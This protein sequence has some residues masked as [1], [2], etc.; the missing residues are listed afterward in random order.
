M[1]PAGPCCLSTPT[2][3]SHSS[4]P[5]WAKVGQ[6]NEVKASS[7]RGF[8]GKE[9]K[10]PYNH[11]PDISIFRASEQVREFVSYGESRVITKN[12]NSYS[13]HKFYHLSLWSFLPLGKK[14]WSLNNVMGWTKLLNTHYILSPRLQHQPGRWTPWSP[15]EASLSSPRVYVVVRM[16]TM[17]CSFLNHHDQWQTDNPL[18]TR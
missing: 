12:S 2:P 5:T 18:S 6:V 11:L 3:T 7:P 13:S 4:S 15:S 16:Y 10:G 8:P 14:E 1:F 17:A 9:P